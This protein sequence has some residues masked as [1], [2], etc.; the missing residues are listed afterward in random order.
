MARRNQIAA[1]YFDGGCGI[2]V[3]GAAKGGMLVKSTLK[4]VMAG[5]PSLVPGGPR[6]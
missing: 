5:T 3:C 2:F 4:Q 6:S 1:L